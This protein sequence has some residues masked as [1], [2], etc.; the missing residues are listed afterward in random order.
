VLGG[1]GL[2]GGAVEGG[3]GGLEGDVFRGEFGALQAIRPEASRSAADTI[4]F[5]S[6][7]TGN[8]VQ[9]SVPLVS[10]THVLDGVLDRASRFDIEHRTQRKRNQPDTYD[11]LGIHRDPLR[12]RE[13][14]AIS[15]DPTQSDA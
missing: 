1:V 5:I 13:A 2:G 7:S 8:T 4:L 12:E 6:T 10:R 9:H 11:A 15:F 14:N 3:L